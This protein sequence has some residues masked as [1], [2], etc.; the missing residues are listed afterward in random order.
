MR[1]TYLA[2]GESEITHAIQLNSERALGFLIQMSEYLSISH[3][4]IAIEKELPNVTTL[5]LQAN[6]PVQNRSW[7]MHEQP[8]IVALKKGDEATARLLLPK[9]NLHERFTHDPEKKPITIEEYLALECPKD[10]RL[11]K[12]ISCL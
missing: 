1:I 3:L 9:V 4:N 8:L 5:L 2:A 11:S 7:R 6:C 12:S 10:A